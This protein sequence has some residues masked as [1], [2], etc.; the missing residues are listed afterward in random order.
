MPCISHKRTIYIYICI[1]FHSESLG[2][3]GTFVNAK[4]ISQSNKA[5]K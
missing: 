2:W 4:E 5:G 3:L 1:D